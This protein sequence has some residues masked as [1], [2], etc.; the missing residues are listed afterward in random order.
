MTFHQ[1]S[2]R[3][4]WKVPASGSITK[5]SYWSLIIGED[6]IYNSSVAFDRL[7]QWR[8]DDPENEFRLIQVTET[9]I[10]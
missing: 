3:I 4:E 10:G 6:D 7:D 1:L 2:Y 8:K 9:C 5:K